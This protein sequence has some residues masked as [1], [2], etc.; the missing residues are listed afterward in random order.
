MLTI[1]VSPHS[2]AEA[3]KTPPTYL[4]GCCVVHR[5]SLEGLGHWSNGE[6]CPRRRKEQHL[7]S[8]KKDHLHTSLKS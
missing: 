5:F 8:S 6:T 7:Q 1:K 3:Y 2:L 4:L